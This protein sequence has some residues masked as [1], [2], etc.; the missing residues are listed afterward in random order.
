M[1]AVKTTAEPS[2][3]RDPE[4]F[5]LTVPEVLDEGAMTQSGRICRHTWTAISCALRTR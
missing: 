5:N 4:K 2:P 3:Q 1:G